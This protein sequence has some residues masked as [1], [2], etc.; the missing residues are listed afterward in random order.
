MLNDDLIPDAARVPRPLRV[1]ADL[2]DN[3]RLASYD[4]DRL[5]RLL[6]DATETLMGHFCGASSRINELSLL[7]QQL[8]ELPD[9]SLHEA[10]AHLSGAVTSLQ[11]QD[12]ASQLIG[13]T[14]RRLHR[15]ADRLALDAAGDGSPGE[16]ALDPA[17][18]RPNPVTQE[19]MDAGSIE[20]F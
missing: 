16:A 13:H 5:Q 8:P 11:F 7:A 2:Q 1:T 15:C 12:M 20:L 19:Q 4:L 6:S 9:H 10:L 14:N 18:L 3:L 17:P